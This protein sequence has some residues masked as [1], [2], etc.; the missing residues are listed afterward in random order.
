MTTV[1]LAEKPSVAKQI[2]QVVGAHARRDGFFEGA[3]FIVTWAVG[4]LVGLA[5][6]GKINA[7]WE[8]W[9]AKQLPMLPDAFPLVVRD[10]HADRL[11]LI[12]R[13]F[14][15]R[16]T[17]R[18]VCATDAGREG[19]LIFRYI[20]E[21]VQCTKPVDRL[22][23]ASLTHDAIAR[24]FKNLKPASAYDALASAARARSEIDWLVGMNLSRAYSL[25]TGAD[26]PLH[27]GRVKTPTLAMVALRDL[28]IA[29]FVPEPYREVVATLRAETGELATTYVRQDFGAGG[30]PRWNPRLP[31]PGTCELDSMTDAAAVLARARSAEFS[32]LQVDHET[33]ASQPP[34]LLDLT[35]L[36]RCANR[37]WGWT[38]QET[39]STA[40]E[41]Y[42]RHGALT[43]PRTDSRHLSADIERELGPVV[44]LLR[45]RFGASVPEG[46]G[47][48]LS[49]RFVNDAEVSD[50]HA[51]IPTG[52]EV[53]LEAGSKPAL[54]FD[55]VCRRLLS[56]WAPDAILATTKVVLEA[57]SAEGR[58]RYEAEGKSVVHP[59][60]RS[61]DLPAVLKPAEAK[62]LPAGLRAGQQL[63]LL[64]ARIVAKE[65]RPPGHFTDATLL[66]AMES[67]GA[68]LDEEQ[69]RA[70]R[71]R[72]LGTPATRGPTI[73]DLVRLGYLRR[74]GK[75]LRATDQGIALVRLVH[76]HVASP[77]LTGDTEAKLRRIEQGDCDS[78]AL[79]RE[80]RDFVGTVV[81]ET[82]SR[83]VPPRRPRAS[84]VVP[85]AKQKGTGGRKAAGAR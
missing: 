79:M 67:A 81:R 21:A 35:E 30:K 48:P 32:V 72:G 53:A 39:L 19:E 47:A 11:G 27:V 54:L 56:A 51:I 46:L 57:A 5:E 49:R 68:S 63:P 44:E 8:S 75:S 22:W 36:Q 55:L 4:H 43:Y 29:H 1:V 37:L 83:G 24:G 85:S 34:Q 74:E 10:G 7:A 58:D 18:I 41:L 76:V 69:A 38:A 14:N 26:R 12:K 80:V 25:A 77:A 31:A 59:G 60:W 2:A 52:A 6:P 61:F 15:A 65:T 50:H 70:M 33:S 64:G 17:R 9:D 45:R 13:V 71:D 66:S 73:E 82:L 62:L 78:A 84:Q 42:E 28:A 40:Q 3:D 16:T 23:I 20:Y